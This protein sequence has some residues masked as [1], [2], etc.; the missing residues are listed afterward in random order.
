[1]S[2]WTKSDLAAPHGKRQRVVCIAGDE[3]YDVIVRSIVLMLA[4]LALGSF[5][6]VAASPAVAGP[7]PSV[8]SLQIRDVAG[9]PIR[10]TVR[11]SVLIGVC[12]TRVDVARLV[13]GRTSVQIRL[14]QTVPTPPV[15]DP[16][17][18]CPAV[19]IFRCVAV[20]LADPLG[21]RSVV[22]LTSGTRFRLGS[23]GAPRWSPTASFKN[24]SP[25]GRVTQ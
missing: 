3:P 22:D 17:T 7:D 20:V 14:T 25:P 5:S 9:S 4:L 21:K 2:L 12:T 6:V 24:C 11:L 1:M 8:S 15:T 10:R 13:Q 16:P 23:T 19:G 18:V